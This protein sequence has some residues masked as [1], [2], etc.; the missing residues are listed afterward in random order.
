MKEKDKIETAILNK[1]DQLGY[2]FQ[3]TSDLLVD[4]HL[5]L[6]SATSVSQSHQ[7]YPYRGNFYRYN[8]IDVSR[9]H[10]GIL[11]IEIKESD[12]KRIIWQGSLD[13]KY[14]RRSKTK[15]DIAELI[16]LIFDT[17]PAPIPNN[18]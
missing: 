12:K 16:S 15:R 11:L 13:L 18:K 7:T 9:Y 10:E 17:F 2:N 1:M 5:I 6:G 3:Q 8:T 4:Y 14:N